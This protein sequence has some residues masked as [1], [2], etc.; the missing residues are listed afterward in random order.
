[1]EDG[2]DVT[3]TV[4][5]HISVFIRTSPFNAEQP[6][7]GNTAFVKLRVGTLDTRNIIAAA[8]MSR[9]QSGA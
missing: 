1:M 2:V 8:V 4:L 6:G 7:Y 5:P 3:L 9:M